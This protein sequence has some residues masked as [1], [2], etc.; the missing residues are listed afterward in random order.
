MSA[1]FSHLLP[2]ARAA[3]SAITARNELLLQ[4]SFSWAPQM[5]PFDP[6]SSLSSKGPEQE[7]ETF[8]GAPRITAHTEYN[9]ARTHQAVPS[10]SVCP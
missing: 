8:P 9:P 2:F 1:F 10:S 6:H 7:I 4:T 3:L 5:C